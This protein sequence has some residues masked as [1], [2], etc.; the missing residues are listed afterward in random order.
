MRNDLHA[1][2]G[3]FWWPCN[4]FFGVLIPGGKDPQSL[5]TI[6]TVYNVISRLIYRISRLIYNKQ[7]AP[8]VAGGGK[9]ASW[10]G[11]ARRNSSVGDRV[12]GN[13]NAAPV[14]PHQLYNIVTH[15]ACNTDVKTKT[16]PRPTRVVI[17]V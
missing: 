8:G 11:D 10:R 15:I 17:R 2:L 12:E 7:D 4:E 5:Y 1:A 16:F 13:K 6:Y 9:H 3:A 14:N